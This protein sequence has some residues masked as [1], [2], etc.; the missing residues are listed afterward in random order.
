MSDD[1]HK[2]GR[3]GLYS[4]LNIGASFEALR[5]EALKADPVLMRTDLGSLDGWLVLDP[6]DAL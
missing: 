1:S 6:S 2:L 5:V 4:W 3:I